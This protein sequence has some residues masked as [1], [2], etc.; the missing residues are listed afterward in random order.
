MIMLFLY[1]A[2]MLWVDPTY[3]FLCNVFPQAVWVVPQEPE[4][5][6]PQQ[7][8]LLQHSPQSSAAPRDRTGI[9]SVGSPRGRHETQ[10]STPASQYRCDAA[11]SELLGWGQALPFTIFKVY[12]LKSREDLSPWF[13]LIGKIP[14]YRHAFQFQIHRKYI[15]VFITHMV[16]IIHHYSRYLY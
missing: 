3:F 8:P 7:K 14:L 4:P 16:C 15:F 1:T 10:T 5:P 13:N 12:K 9:S 11:V 6:R 2:R